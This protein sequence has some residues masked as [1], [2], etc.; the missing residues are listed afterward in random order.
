MESGYSEYEY[1]Y[2]SGVYSL[3]FGVRE[4]DSRTTTSPT[5][6]YLH[7]FPGSALEAQMLHAAALAGN[8]RIIS[9]DRPGF[10]KSVSA[11][12][13]GVSVLEAAEL[14]SAGLKER[15]IKQY[16]I[17]AVSGGC[18]YA[19]ALASCAPES[20]EKVVIV[21]GLGELRRDGALEGMIAENRFLLKLAGVAPL[22]CRPGIKVMADGWRN[23]PELMF[24]CMA[25][26]LPGEDREILRDISVIKPFGTSMQRSVAS[27]HRGP[28]EELKRILERWKIPFEKIVTDV[29]IFH[30]DQDRYV[31]LHHGEWLA[32]KLQKANL[33]VQPGRGHFMAARMANEILRAACGVGCGIFAVRL[34]SRRR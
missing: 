3:D 28:Y 14:I 9:F 1:A 27:G 19:L 4:V 21:S 8:V 34:S 20:V 10:G 12:V 18:P 16:S 13:I 30:G 33:F 15:G 17:A 22:L 6:V 24:R 25:R 2:K 11:A 29:D 23:Q 31:P 5:M 32:A 7:G 26:M